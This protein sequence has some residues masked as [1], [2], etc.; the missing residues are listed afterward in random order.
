MDLKLWLAEKAA[1]PA[2]SPV[3]TVVKAV[4]S[5]LGGIRA[6]L[7]FAFM[8]FFLW[9]SHHWQDKA[10]ELNDSLEVAR[11]DLWVAKQEYKR[12]SDQLADAKGQAEQA[13]AERDAAMKAAAKRLA[14]REREWEKVYGAKP[15]NRAWADQRVPADIYGR[16]RDH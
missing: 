10:R 7:W 6:S 1:L 15:E 11:S 13:R 2:V 9:S 4:V 14:A 16:L 8:L 5:I 3:L 12:L